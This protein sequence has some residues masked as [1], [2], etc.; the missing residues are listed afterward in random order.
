M[1]AGGKP[2]IS[3]YA[4]GISGRDALMK[5]L[6]SC[7]VCV[8]FMRAT[9]RLPSDSLS[10]MDVVGL[11]SSTPFHSPAGAELLPAA[12]WLL[13]APALPPRVLPDPAN[14]TYLHKQ[15]QDEA[16]WMSG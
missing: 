1:G 14:A 16:R 13:L 5:R 7:T 3:W 11:L 4:A 2:V 8:V 9:M 10:W 12:A 6:M 15:G